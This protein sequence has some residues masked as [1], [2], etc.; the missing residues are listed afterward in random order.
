MILLVNTGLVSGKNLKTL[1]FVQG[2]VIHQGSG[3]GT[4]GTYGVTS[5]KAMGG[6]GDLL[7]SMLEKARKEAQDKLRDEAKKLGADAVVNVTYHSAMVS[8]NAAEIVYSGTAV[9]YT[10]GNSNN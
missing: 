10:R 6:G 2:V 9:K 5:L 8:A 4:A 1:G 3:G 7:T